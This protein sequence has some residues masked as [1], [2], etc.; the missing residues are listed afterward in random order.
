MSPNILPALKS[1][2]MGCAQLDFLALIASHFQL[3]MKCQQILLLW[4][5]YLPP[6][7]LCV[8]R[9]PTSKLP[10]GLCVKKIKNQIENDLRS[11]QMHASLAP[12][13]PLALIVQF[14]IFSTFFKHITGALLGEPLGSIYSRCPCVFHMRSICKSGSRSNAQ[15]YATR[16]GAGQMR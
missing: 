2:H 9:H 10:T 6:A 3:L 16:H 12:A 4:S 8:A 15:T 11:N 14:K 13:I 7:T 1:Y 5:A